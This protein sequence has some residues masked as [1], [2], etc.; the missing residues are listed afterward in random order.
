[1]TRWA[2][3]LMWTGW[4]LAL[5]LALEDGN[6]A[7]P[8]KPPPAEWPQFRGPDGQG[9]ADARD[10]PLTWSEQ[11]NIAWKVAVPGL[12]WSSPVI[13]G[14][15]VWLTTALDKPPSLRA[16]CLDRATGRL[17][18]DVEVFAPRAYVGRHSKN[19]FATPGPVIEGDRVY[20][21]FGQ[22]GTA[23]LS[24]QG[25]ILW[26]TVL[27]HN[28]LYGPSSTPVLFEDLLIIPCQGTDV[29]YVTALD[30]QTGKERWKTVCGGNY[31]S[32]STPLVIRV[33]QVDQVVCNLTNKVVA[34]D[35]HTGKL[36]WSASNG[37]VAQVPR[38]VFGHGLV[39]AGGGYFN[40]VFQ[41]IRPD[42]AG[43]VT[44]THVVWEVKKNVPQNPSPLLVGDELYLV[45]DQGI[46]S[47]LNARTGE[48]HWRERL[49]G[50][51]WASPLFAPGRIYF[52]N[53]D[54]VTTVLAPGVKFAKLATNRLDGRTLASLA[55]AG[56]AIYLRS[57]RHLYRIEKK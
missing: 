48:E 22:M 34:L 28:L 16:L 6:A 57:D 1:M 42:G 40:P 51:Y 45:S 20:V 26:T 3:N 41:A 30:K 55:V 25:Q 52:T 43:D 33:G 12:G 44:R 46:A 15:Q 4:L 11:E 2:R 5:G 18:H 47:C 37:N 36:L 10:L 27:P 7:P 21:H 17:L 50:N 56:K 54:G 32:D 35:V 23:C 39:F 19:G 14:R 38:P 24:T 49:A 13:Q 9:H 53:E 29:R 31:N 8:D